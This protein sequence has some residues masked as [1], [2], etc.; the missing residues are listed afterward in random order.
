MVHSL[1]PFSI[2]D[3]DIREISS[4]WHLDYYGISRQRLVEFK[5]EQVKN[6][7]VDT[8]LQL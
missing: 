7:M 3:I 4:Q 8:D 6:L 1:I 5:D 2:N